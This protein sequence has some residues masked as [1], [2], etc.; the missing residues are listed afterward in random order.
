ML[1]LTNFS[2]MDAAFHVHTVEAMHQI[3]WNDVEKPDDAVYGGRE[4][5]VTGNA[6]IGSKLVTVIDFERILYEINPATGLQLAEISQMGPRER[7]GKPVVIAEDSVF[8]QRTLIEAMEAAGY[9]NIRPFSNGLE[10]WDYLGKLRDECAEKNV[11]I[12][13]KV[14]AV[15][16]DIEMPRM[17]G[18]RLTSLI[19]SDNALKRIPVMI[20]SSLIDEAMRVKGEALGIDAQLSKPQI[21]SLVETLDR[22]IL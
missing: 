2:N 3:D 5:L 4:S 9:S 20:F 15:I 10:A 22:L 8:L 1:M 17:D 19:K 21:G 14:A 11:P 12:E 6:R 7:S 16:T 18:H 13:S